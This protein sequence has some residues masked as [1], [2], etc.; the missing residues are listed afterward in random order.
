[1]I[2]KK[3]FK[4]GATSIYVVVITMLLLAVITTSFI[5]IIAT[6]A[7]RT[8]NNELA[9]AAYDS[10]LAGVEDTK[11]ALKQYFAC[12]QDTKIKDKD[13]QDKCETIKREIEEGFRTA[14]APT[15]DS[16]YGYCDSIAMALGRIEEKGSEVPI[17]ETSGTATNR[18]E[19]AY[20]C[21]MIDR[22]LDD[23]RSTLSANTPMRAIPLKVDGNPNSVTGIRILWY[24]SD[25]GPLE[26]LNY[27]AEEYLPTNKNDVA[28]PPILSAHIVQTA[29]EYTL[30]QFDKTEGDRT[31]NATVVLRPSKNGTN[32]INKNKLL[33]SNTHTA[34]EKINRVD[35]TND[36]ENITCRKDNDLSS[37]FA[38]VAA[39]Q[40]PKPIG[41]DDRRADTFYLFLSLPYE[42]PKT[43]FSVQLCTDDDTQ[44]GNCRNE[45][46]NSLSIAK[47]KDGQFAVDS[48]GRANNMYSRVEARIEF[49]DI[50][51]PLP[52]HALYATS[53]NGS[54]EKSFYVTSNCFN[55]NTQTNTLEECLNSGSTKH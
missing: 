42:R 22:T 4:Q 36:A 43:T 11:L 28:T 25:D 18:F 8:A 51:S 54:I 34:I 30:E 55:L 39:M 35:Y 14:D 48:T 23:Y 24:T 29:Q 13:G 38:C 10:A 47:I 45:N 17:Q 16:N 9:K 20:T 37:D 1:M 32:Y 53:E 19:Q 3:R 44:P 40:L 6:E 21:V 49:N 52:E 5:R 26:D 31:N 33:K 41:G 12:L 2:L 46:N 15:D 7:T 50:Y 27:N